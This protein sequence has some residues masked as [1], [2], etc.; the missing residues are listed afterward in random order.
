M[1]EMDLNFGGSVVK[2]EAR[3]IDDVVSKFTRDGWEETGRVANGRLVYLEKSGVN[4]TAIEG[5][6]GTVLIPSGPIRGVVFGNVN[7][8]SRTSVIGAGRKSR[9]KDKQ[10]SKKQMNR[11]KRDTFL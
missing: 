11:E 6:V 7:L 2:R 8:F 4:I 1:P 3:P 5:P 10:K 9:S